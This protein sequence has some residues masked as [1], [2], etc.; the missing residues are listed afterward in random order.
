[1]AQVLH[2]SPG[3]KRLKKNEVTKMHEREKRQ[4]MIDPAMKWW[5]LG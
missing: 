3:K 1:M 5:T 2:K 4:S